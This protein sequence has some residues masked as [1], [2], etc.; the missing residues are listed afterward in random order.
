MDQSEQHFVDC[1]G[2]YGNQMCMGGLMTNTFNY[3]IQEKR[4]SMDELLYPVCS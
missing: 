4:G 1:S 2:G 3:M